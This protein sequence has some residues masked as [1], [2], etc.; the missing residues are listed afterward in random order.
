MINHKGII[1]ARAVY[2][3]CHYKQVGLEGFAGTISGGVNQV[4]RD[5]GIQADDILY[6]FLGLPGYGEDREAGE[7]MLN[8][9]KAILKRNFRCGNDS[10]AGWAGATGC[11]PGINIVSGTG[12]IV[13]G[14]DDGGLSARSGGWGDFCGDEGSAH[15]IAKKLIELFA[16]QSDGRIPKTALYGMV[17]ASMGLEEDFDIIKLLTDGYGT[18]RDKVAGLSRL[19]Y[20]AAMLGDTECKRIFAEAAQELAASVAAVMKKLSFKGSG[21]IPV[22]CTGGVFESGSL[23]KEPLADALRGISDRLRLG[24]PLLQP[25]VGSAYYAWV[26]RNGE[27][28][29]MVLASLKEASA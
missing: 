12:S 10:E 16:K 21:I 24:Q 15:W 20:E 4:C 2:G 3:T 6:S 8:A 29:D 9:V 27:Y 22:T 5:A 14:K 25:D 17:K 28:D 1:A 26:I 13:F 7:L 23:I 18:R 11:R 19:A